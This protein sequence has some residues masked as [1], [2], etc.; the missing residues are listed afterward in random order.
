MWASS[1]HELTVVSAA[2]NC[3]KACFEAAGMAGTIGA[4]ARSRMREY[5]RV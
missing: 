5:T 1:H 2:W 4:I 3:R